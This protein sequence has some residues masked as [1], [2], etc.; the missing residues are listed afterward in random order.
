MQAQI[1]TVPR[2]SYLIPGQILIALATAGLLIWLVFWAQRG[3]QHGGIQLLAL[4]SVI[5]VQTFAS[6]LYYARKLHR[7]FPGLYTFAEKY[8]LLVQSY[9][10][11]AL[12]SIAEP[13]FKAAFAE[14]SRRYRRICNVIGYIAIGFMIWVYAHHFSGSNTLF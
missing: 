9:G 11:E 4:F 5:L 6:A 12:D 10:S 2:K 8:M 3:W 1:P 14:E 13:S 7:Q